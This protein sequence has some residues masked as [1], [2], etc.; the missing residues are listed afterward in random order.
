MLVAGDLQPPV[1]Y[2]DRWVLLAGASVLA[3]AGYY[4]LAWWWTRPRRAP[5]P[6]RDRGSRERC[7]T[8]LATIERSA[9]AQEVSAREAHQ[10]VSRVVRDFVTAT[11]GPRA[12]TMT[13]AALRREAPE[14]LAELVAA[15]YPPEFGPGEARAAHDLATS[16]ARARE[17]VTTWP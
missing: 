12:E 3:V 5:R 11:T 4:A 2:D 7:L 6:S 15:L 16:L 9:A 8:A 10:Q 14:P 13:L 1:G 17:L